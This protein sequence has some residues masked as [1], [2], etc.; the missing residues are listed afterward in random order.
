[1]NNK[2][3]ISEMS[4]RTGLSASDTQTMINGLVAE[5][6]D[7]LVSEGALTIKQF[8]A[9]EVKKKVERVCLTPTGQRVLVPP[10]LALSFKPSPALRERIGEGEEIEL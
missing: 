5:M 9:F 4:K 2:Q 7:A 10:R 3:L 1:M 6:T 8:G